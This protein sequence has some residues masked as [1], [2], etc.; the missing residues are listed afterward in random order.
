MEYIQNFNRKF[1]LTRSPHVQFTVNEKIISNPYLIS[2]P[3]E[4]DDL[5]NIELKYITN[6]TIDISYKILNTADQ[7]TLLNEL[8]EDIPNNYIISS[9]YNYNLLKPKPLLFDALKQK[10]NNLKEVN[11]DMV[12]ENGNL[13]CKADTNKYVNVIYQSSFSASNFAKSFEFFDQCFFFLF[14]IIIIQLL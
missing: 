14:I 13:K 9:I 5:T 1:L 7:I 2:T 10:N 6:T 3:F 8:F 12:M 4:A 11:W